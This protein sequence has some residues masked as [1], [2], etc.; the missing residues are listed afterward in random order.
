MPVRRTTSN[1]KPA[2]QYGKSGTKY[3]YTAG[4]EDSRERAK[5]K[6]I[7]QGL[8]IQQSQRRAGRRVD[9]L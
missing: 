6:A 9:P 3:T 4:N 5:K 1:G 8:A 7:T 2:Y